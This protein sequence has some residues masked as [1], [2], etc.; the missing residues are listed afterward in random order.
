MSEGITN[1][2]LFAALAA[3]VLGTILAIVGYYVTKPY[4]QYEEGQFYKTGNTAVASLRLENKGYRDAEE[5]IIQ[6]AFTE[7]II[8]I[9]SGDAVSPLTVTSGGKG[10]KFIV[11]TIP[12]V[13]PS[14]ST[15]VYFAIDNSSGGVG[16]GAQSFVKQ[17]TF[18]GGKGS[19]QPPLWTTLPYIIVASLVGLAMSFFVGGYFNKSNE[20]K[21]IRDFVVEQTEKDKQFNKEWREQLDK[22]EADFKKQMAED[23]ERMKRENEEWTKRLTK[24]DAGS[25]S[26]SS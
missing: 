4:I 17:V 7:T 9:T 18:K 13:V 21:A 14:Q 19:N 16:E 15:Y 20:L 5:V 6:T 22:Q 1:N 2:K 23:T 8:D 24:G 12:R 26:E 11:G 10:F 25:T 3:V